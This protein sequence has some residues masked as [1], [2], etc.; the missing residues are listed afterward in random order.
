MPVPRL[1]LM[2]DAIIVALLHMYCTT[3]TY[4]VLGEYLRTRNSTHSPHELLAQVVVIAALQACDSF[5]SIMKCFIQRMSGACTTKAWEKH[6]D[7]VCRDFSHFPIGDSYSTNRTLHLMLD[8]ALTNVLDR[9]IRPS[10]N[11][12]KPVTPPIIVPI[13]PAI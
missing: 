10:S 8:M 5:L 11:L 2:H 13:G 12:L 4:Q 6:R 1:C 3:W 7:A 9:I